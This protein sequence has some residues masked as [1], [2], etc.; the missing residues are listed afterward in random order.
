MTLSI[1]QSNFP[2][3]SI[4][5]FFIAHS[6]SVTSYKLRFFIQL[7]VSSFICKTISYSQLLMLLFAFRQ[8]SVYSYY[9]STLNHISI[10]IF[11]IKEDYVQK[12]NSWPK[13][14]LINKYYKF[15]CIV[16]S[17]TKIV[18]I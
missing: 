2:D 17:A 14:N 5:I 18:L 13:N 16:V 12:Q 7:N 4:T 10:E 9:M 8:V 6:L 1:K 11:S 3:S 15:I